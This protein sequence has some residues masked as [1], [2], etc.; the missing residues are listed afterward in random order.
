MQECV[1][2]A[3]SSEQSRAGSGESARKRNDDFPRPI[4]PCYIRAKF[5]HVSAECP[6]SVRGRAQP[7]TCTAA[8]LARL[9]QATRGG[10]N[11]RNCFLW[12]LLAESS[13]KSAPIISR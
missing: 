12:Q 9:N 13:Y 8:A 5:A 6:Q 10:A 1:R 7:P 2:L 11:I 4:R 3:G